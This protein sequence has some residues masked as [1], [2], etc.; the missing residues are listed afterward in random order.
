MALHGNAYSRF[1][2]WMKIVLPL[3][4]LALLSTLFLLSRTTQTDPDLPFSDVDLEDR[5][6][7]QR[8]TAPQ[9]AGTTANGASINVSARSARPDP[10]APGRASAEA[11]EALFRLA[12][13]GK[14]EMRAD[15]A[16]LDEGADEAE[17]RGGV[18]VQSS[19]GYEVRTERL[20]SG[21]T[22]MR[23]ES[24]GEVTGTGPAGRFTAGRMV[25]TSDAETGDVQLRFTNGVK[26]VYDP[27]Q[28]G[29][30]E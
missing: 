24:A 25:M 29:S 1:V 20:V 7:E 28:Q 15:E 13:G 27:K 18:L 23:A 5:I 14:V 6:K 11:V 2:A 9:Y 26:L 10:D 21:L 17:L 19:T 30:S 16:I 8:I 12:D 3:A 22:E 4:A